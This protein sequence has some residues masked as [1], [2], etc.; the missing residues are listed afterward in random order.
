MLTSA[1]VAASWHIS[2]IPGLS[3]LAFLCLEPNPPQSI[4]PQLKCHFSRPF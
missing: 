3:L 4:S 2:P 1:T